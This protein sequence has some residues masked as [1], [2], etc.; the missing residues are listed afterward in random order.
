MLHVTRDTE[1]MEC[2]QE[3]SS[4]PWP[5]FHLFFW[6]KNRQNRWT[7]FILD[8]GEEIFKSTDSQVALEADG[9]PL[10]V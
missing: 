8:R 9:L 5:T 1:N 3:S 10:E 2:L 6:A 4:L 7:D